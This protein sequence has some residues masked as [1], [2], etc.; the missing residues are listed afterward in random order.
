M[1]FL[2]ISAVLV[3]GCLGA[4]LLSLPSSP[5]LSKEQLTQV[6][7]NYGPMGQCVLCADMLLILAS[8]EW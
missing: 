2:S 8:I 6:T 4:P 5:L 3:V 7:P 1:R